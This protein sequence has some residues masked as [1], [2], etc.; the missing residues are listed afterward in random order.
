MYCNLV[1]YTLVLKGVEEA[2]CHFSITSRRTRL[3]VH[4]QVPRGALRNIL[5]QIIIMS[6]NTYAFT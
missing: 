3:G 1:T 4:T 6:A 5:I 2:V